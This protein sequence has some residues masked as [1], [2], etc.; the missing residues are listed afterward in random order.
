MG[1]TGF[2]EN[3]QFSAVSCESL[4]FPAVFCANLRLPNPLPKAPFRTKN[5]TALKIRSILLRP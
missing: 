5:S 4:R 2:C 3:L 1:E